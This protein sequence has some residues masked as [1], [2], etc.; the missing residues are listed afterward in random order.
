MSYTLIGDTV[1]VASRLTTRARVGEVLM[2][3]GVL[4][5]VHESE[6]TVDAVSLPPL[7]IRSKEQ[8]LEAYCLTVFE[9][10]RGDREK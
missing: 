9:R 10:P 6:H 5:S 7:I 1:N 4:D 3:K 2:S 8:P